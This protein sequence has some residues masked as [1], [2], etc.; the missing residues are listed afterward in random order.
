M[1]FDVSVFLLTTFFCTDSVSCTPHHFLCVF[2]LPM[3][4]PIQLLVELHVYCEWLDIVATTAHEL[5]TFIDSAHPLELVY[6]RKTYRLSARRSDEACHT[7]TFCKPQAVKN[8]AA[9]FEF[10]SLSA[11]MDGWKVISMAAGAK[12]GSDYIYVFSKK[13]KANMIKGAE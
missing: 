9:L 7:L 6:E 10:F 2:P 13:N 4:I 1:S 12:Y 8:R 3:D 11:R 5:N